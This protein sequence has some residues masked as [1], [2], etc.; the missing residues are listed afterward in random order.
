MRYTKCQRCLTGNEARYRAHTDVMEMD[1]CAK[2]AREARRLG[3]S[4]A[5]LVYGDDPY[6]PVVDTGI[7]GLDTGCVA[8]ACPIPGS[9]KERRNP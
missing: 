5:F 7:V 6:A 2:C 4:L 3:I 8:E 1:I 9:A